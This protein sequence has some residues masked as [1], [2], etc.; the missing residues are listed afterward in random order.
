MA[1]NYERR[2]SF[3]YCP[4]GC[5]RSGV[6]GCAASGGGKALAVGHKI[7]PSQVHSILN[8]GYYALVEPF[9]EDEELSRLFTFKVNSAFYA[10]FCALMHAN[11]YLTLQQLTNYRIEVNGQMVSGKKLGDEYI[12]RI[13][14]SDA[15]AAAAVAEAWDSETESWNSEQLKRYWQWWLLKR[16]RRHGI[17]V[18]RSNQ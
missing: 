14:A 7:A 5:A 13:G 3:A 6:F 2:E 9:M 12:A 1:V 4:G 11:G 16:C 18:P 10:A 15:A 17:L 8:P